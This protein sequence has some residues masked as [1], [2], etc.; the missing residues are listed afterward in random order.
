MA[1]PTIALQQTS[2]RIQS[3][4]GLLVASNEEILFPENSEIIP[5]NQISADPG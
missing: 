2:G 5:L 3:P 1:G 4:I